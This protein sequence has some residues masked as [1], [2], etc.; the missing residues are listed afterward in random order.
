MKV[1]IKE[2]KKLLADGKK[3]KVLTVNNDY[4]P[5]EKYVEKGILQT[6]LVTLE[7]GYS[8][9]V[10]KEHRFFTN[11]GWIFC[12]DLI[13]EKHSIL[14]DDEKYS[15]VKSIE[16][17]GE[18]PIVD[19]MID[20]KEHS[21]FGNGMLNHNTGKSLLVSHALAETQKQ[22][23]VAVFID[24]EFA[25][26]RDFLSAIG[27]DTSKLIYMPME[28]LEEIF[29]KIEEIIEHVR[30]KQGD[31]IV[32]IVVDSVMGATCKEELEADYGVQGYATHKARIISAAMRKINGLISR[33]KVCLIFT[34]Q[35]RMNVG[36]IGFGVDKYTTSGGKGIGFHASLRL[37]LK[38]LAKLK[39]KDKEVIGVK[40]GFDIKKSRLGSSYRT[41]EF[42]IFFD[43]GMDDASTWITV[44][45][46]CGAIVK[47]KEKK[48]HYKLYDAVDESLTFPKSEL[49]GV[50]QDESIKQ[51]ILDKILESYQVNYRSAGTAVS[52][53]TDV[54]ENDDF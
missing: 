22:N 8:E 2:I 13:V 17:I 6:F 51:K 9:K 45:E 43:R 42:D 53:A 33:Q 28:M 38:T 11:A 34:N 20:S 26:S 50:L 10:S 24:S 1:Q 40:T 54:D 15:K 47:A 7:N 19:I 30:K 4:V 31:K 46:N 41:G 25:V 36:A 5:I 12:K 37:R 29:L 21:Y 3:I 27:V 44:S 49:M 39:N 32:T 16:Y 52:I 48:T 14:C 23:G 18:F 35:L